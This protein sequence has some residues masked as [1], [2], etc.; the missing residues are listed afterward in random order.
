MI[1]QEEATEVAFLA[2]HKRKALLISVEKKQSKEKQEREKKERDSN[3]VV[4]KKGKFS[5]CPHSKKKV[6]LRT[7]VG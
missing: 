2:F 5:T 3:K 1:K 4:R 6:T 7:T